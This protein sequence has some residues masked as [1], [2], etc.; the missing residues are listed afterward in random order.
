MVVRTHF[1]SC[2]YLLSFCLK[3]F[4]MFEQEISVCF[5]WL[6]SKICENF[7]WNFF[8]NY[9]R[10][11]KKLTSF[12]F[13]NILQFLDMPL[14]QII[15]SKSTRKLVFL[16]FQRIKVGYCRDNFGSTACQDSKHPSNRVFQYSSDMI[17]CLILNY[18]GRSTSRLAG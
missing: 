17:E 3:S 8:H 12:D 9:H 16:K 4:G 7:I 18:S 1:I 6:L 13:I 2:R 11:M 14:H 5:D 10:E 15:H